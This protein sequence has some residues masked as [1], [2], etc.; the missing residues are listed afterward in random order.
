MTGSGKTALHQKRPELQSYIV[1]PI[2][3]KVL[4]DFWTVRER[5]LIPIR[6]SVNE[7]PKKNLFVT[8]R[9]LNTFNSPALQNQ[10]GKA[11]NAVSGIQL[12]FCYH[13]QCTSVQATG[14]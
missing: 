7:I 9:C 12:F 14:D 8:F 5:N 11:E 2:A 13:T 6:F 1:A 4:H 3:I 10:A